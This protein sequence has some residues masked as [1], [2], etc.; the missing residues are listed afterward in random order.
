MDLGLSGKRARV[1]G[2]SRGLGAAVA[3]SL[4]REGASV[5]AA[6]RSEADT[7]AWIAQESPDVAAR[8]SAARSD[9]A[10]R[11]SVDALADT[12]LKDGGVDIVVNNSG[13]PP[14]GPAAGTALDLWLK[15]FEAMRSE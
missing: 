7:Q 3:R 8:L 11:A 2:A 6:A 15:Q 13:G 5:V 9:L 4:A 12:L 10:D 14:P 1:L